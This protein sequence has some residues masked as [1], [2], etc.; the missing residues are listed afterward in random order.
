[1]FNSDKTVRRALLTVITIASLASAARAQDRSEVVIDD[2]GVQAESMTSSQDGAVYFGSTA[3][4]TI[5]RAASGAS[6][7]EAWIP[8]ATAG[9]T[10]VLGV[11]SMIA[12]SGSSVPATFQRT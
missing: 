4:G 6:R 1:M 7:A 11:A 5:Y 3:K 12:D 2:T 8:A 10:N 9:L